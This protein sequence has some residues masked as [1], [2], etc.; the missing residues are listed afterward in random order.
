[1]TVCV[2][3]CF[4]S[5][6]ISSA[7]DSQRGGV[8]ASSV[9]SEFVQ[10]QR[11]M[12]D[13]PAVLSAP[14]QAR[15][16]L[17]GQVVAVTAPPPHAPVVTVASAQAPVTTASF[18]QAPARPEYATSISAAPVQAPVVEPPKVP[19]MTAAVGNSDLSVS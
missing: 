7:C 16:E 5:A 10:R 19:A 2:M 6:N 15:A 17:P 14:V 3:L 4:S 12:K 13:E 11:V 8:M 18:V 9:P 1:M